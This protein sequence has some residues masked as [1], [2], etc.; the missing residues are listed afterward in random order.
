MS[1]STV[2]ED[3]AVIDKARRITLL[4]MDVDGVLTDGKLHYG[5]SGELYK[6]FSIKDGLGIK[7]L[8]KAGVDTAVITGRISAA[9]HHRCNE[10]GIK[11]IVQGR[12]DKK[13]AL[14][15]LCTD[16]NRSI[17]DVAYI[18]DD[19]PDIGAIEAA[20][21]GAS[22]ADAHPEV[23]DRANWVSSLPGGHGAV[24]ELADLILKAADRY[25]TALDDY[26]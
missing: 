18:G 25:E 16:L 2:A 5:E 8:Q 13:L 9:T 22:V 14:A 15:E 4:V 3:R 19:W 26:A 6:S 1:H 20:G 21:L 10:L 24:R 17:E 12:E 7:L 23:K 11:H